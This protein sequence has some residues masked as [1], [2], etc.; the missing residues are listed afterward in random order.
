MR[1]RRVSRFFAIVAGVS[2]FMIY[3]IRLLSFSRSREATYDVWVTGGAL[4]MTTMSSMVDGS[5]TVMEISLG[6]IL[7][8][9]K[10]KQESSSCN[11]WTRKFQAALP[12]SNLSMSTLVSA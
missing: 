2:H 12:D 5:E 8:K 10:V 6:T 3:N 4:Q 7:L 1:Y 11:A 9:V